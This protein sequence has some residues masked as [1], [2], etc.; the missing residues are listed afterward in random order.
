MRIATLLT[1]L[2]GPPLVPRC[3]EFPPLVAQSPLRRASAPA[4]TTTLEPPSSAAAAAAAPTATK[5]AAIAAAPPPSAA[6][7]ALASRLS[8]RSFVAAPWR[9]AFTRLMTDAA[10]MEHG[11]ARTA[12]KLEEKWAFAIGA[13]TMADVHRDVTLLPPQFVAH[14]VQWG[15][16]IFNKPMEEGFS[17]DDV[18]KTMDAAT[19]VM[20]NAGFVVPTL[21]HVSL[22]MID[23]TQLPIWLNVYLSKPGLARSTQLHTDKQDVLLVQTTGRKRWRVY[24]P[25][26]PADAPAHDP[27]AR[28]KGTDVMEER[29]DDLL[30][31]TVMRPGDVL[32]IPAGF[33]HE[34]DTTELGGD[35]SADDDAL[36]AQPSVHLT[37]G[38]DTHL[39]AL[40]YAKLREVRARR[41]PVHARPRRR[42]TAPTALTVSPRHPPQVAL[43]KAGESTALASGA[44]V[45]TLPLDRWSQLHAPLALGFLAAP[46]LAPVVDGSSAGGGEEAAEAAEAR[47][48]EALALDGAARMM[49]AEPERWAG[50]EPAALAAS[51]DL[52]GAARRM[53]DHHREVLGTQLRSY[54]RAAHAAATP[55]HRERQ[56]FL[57][58]LNADMDELD[59]SMA[60]LDGWAAGDAAPEAEAAGFGG[61]GG[62]GG[63]GKGKAKAKKNKK[64]R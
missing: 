46:L 5:L 25:P 29:P 2:A 10:F 24:R 54:A 28:G 64:K 35:V 44:P 48:A 15:E 51:L 11:W 53:L 62:G 31:D 22:A 59:A 60:S 30:I 56:A 61:G 55:T 50:Q 36:A 40:S 23:A 43:A 42:P 34:T 6:A 9:D 18:D 27:F 52:G 58:A 17:A 26:P 3:T 38:L 19:V 13:Y 21:A 12:F 63:G 32:Y 33:P 7:F 41:P 37:V 8:T 47:L 49:A 39:W 57:K 1:A 20:L 4:L 16:G 14:G 45:G